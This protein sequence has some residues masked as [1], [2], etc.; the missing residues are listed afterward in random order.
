MIVIRVSVSL[1]TCR[2]RVEYVLKVVFS[3]GCCYEGF[4]LV[5]SAA[6]STNIAPFMAPLVF[7]ILLKLVQGV[8]ALAK[9]AEIGCELSCFSCIL[10]TVGTKR[11]SITKLVVNPRLLEC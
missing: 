8:V 1:E 5:V 11:I 10:A 3:K 4:V 2:N 7:T 6:L 9:S